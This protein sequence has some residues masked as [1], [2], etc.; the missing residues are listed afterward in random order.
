[1]LAQ[2]WATACA[3]RSAHRRGPALSTSQVGTHPSRRCLYCTQR[4]GVPPPSQH[5]WH[6]KHAFWIA[7]FPSIEY[8][9]LQPASGH[10][11]CLLDLCSPA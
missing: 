1:M 6:T 11:S 7:H 3:L 9:R 10:A 8:S 5:A 2:M 4:L